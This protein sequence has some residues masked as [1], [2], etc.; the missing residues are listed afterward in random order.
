MQWC[1]VSLAICFEGTMIILI[2]DFRKR[3]RG[4][5]DHLIV[6]PKKLDVQAWPILEGNMWDYPRGCK[7]D[8]VSISCICLVLG[9]LAF[10]FMYMQTLGLTMV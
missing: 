1:Q 6:L 10:N 9:Y 7:C 8:C 5:Y 3:H 4:T 2:G